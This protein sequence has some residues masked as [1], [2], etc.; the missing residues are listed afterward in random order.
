MSSATGRLFPE[1]VPLNEILYRH[2]LSTALNDEILSTSMGDSADYS[3]QRYAARW[4]L[5]AG[6]DSH[7]FGSL[8][9][10]QAGP[11]YRQR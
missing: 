7:D 3:K 4:Q 8:L 2:K 10:I 9:Y 11:T 6:V 5:G 1:A